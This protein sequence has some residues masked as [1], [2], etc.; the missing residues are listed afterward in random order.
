MLYRKLRDSTRLTTDRR[1]DTVK[2]LQPKGNSSESK[3]Q[4][5]LELH[6][7]AVAVVVAFFICWAPFH[8]QRLFSKYSSEFLSKDTHSLYLKI[9]EIITYISGVLYYVSA[10]INPIL[11]NIMSAKFREAFK[12][13]FTRCC[14]LSCLKSRRPERSYSVLSRSALTGCGA[15]EST[16]E[17]G[18]EDEHTSQTHT[19]LLSNKDS[20]QSFGDSSVEKRGT[21]RCQH[22]AGQKVT[23][24]SHVC[25]SDSKCNYEMTLRNLD[26][27][28][29]HIKPTENTNDK[30]SKISGCCQFFEC[31]AQENQVHRRKFSAYYT[32][33]YLEADIL[34]AENKNNDDSPCD[35][36]NS[37][38][39][40]VEKEALDDELTAYMKEI[41]RR[42]QIIS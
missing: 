28:A 27:I 37:S 1:R 10:T 30:N 11:Y 38:L 36:S 22:E 25:P 9:Y 3:R 19:T 21:K 2:N 16:T 6:Q 17:S 32:T 23:L 42:G 20:T 5:V 8:L 14:H 7:R 13:T 12:E 29:I 31:I 15:R 34:A 35:I 40:D 33:H 39:K 26:F 4:I 24:Q 41:Q 18:K